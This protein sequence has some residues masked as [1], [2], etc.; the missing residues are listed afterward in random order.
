ML[1]PT[2]LRSLF[3]IAYV[4][5]TLNYMFHLFLLKSYREQ[6]DTHT[7]GT[8]IVNTGFSK[9]DEVMGVLEVKTCRL[10]LSLRTEE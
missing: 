1:E 6:D 7:K 2:P 10:L 9:Y 4:I 5:N 3:L 8:S